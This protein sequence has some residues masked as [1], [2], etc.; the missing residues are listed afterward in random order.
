MRSQIQFSREGDPLYHIAEYIIILTGRE[1][2]ARFMGHDVYRTADFDI[3][4]LNSNVSTQN[5]PHP[6]ERHLLALVRSH[7][8]GGHFLFSYSWDLSTRLQTQW[9]ESGNR[10][11][12]SL[13]EQVNGIAWTQMF[14]SDSLQG[15]R[16]VFL[17]QVR[18]SCYPSSEALTTSL[19]SCSQG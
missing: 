5:A 1:H 13:W 10:H 8:L 15:G 17:E 12:T 7:L 4:P 16:Q 6:V 3:L 19:G 18:R 14:V 2:R 11:E 9:S